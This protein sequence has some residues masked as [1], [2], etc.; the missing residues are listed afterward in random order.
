MSDKNLRKQYR[1]QSWL[2]A[3]R[4]QKSSGLTIGQWCEQHQV[5]KYQFYYRQRAVRAAMAESLEEHAA[6]NHSQTALACSDFREPASCQKRESLPAKADF[7]QVPQSF[8]PEPA[9]AAMRIRRGNVILEISNDASD[10]IL[11]ILREVI[12]DV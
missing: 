5:T 11:S 3:I 10:R 4:D 9:G 7:V 8:I 12:R 2:E 6:G 1:L